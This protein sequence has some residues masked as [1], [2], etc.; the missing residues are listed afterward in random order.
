MTGVRRFSQIP[1]ATRGPQPGDQFVAVSDGTVDTLFSTEQVAAS[2]AP[3]ATFDTLGVVMPD[4][5]TTFVSASGV[6]SAPA[7]GAG[8]T[9][10]SATVTAAQLAAIGTTPVTVIPAP[11]ADLMVVVMSVTYAIV[12]GSVGFS[13]GGSGCGLYYGSPTNGISADA[14]G[15]RN[16][17][18][19]VGENFTSMSVGVNA[20]GA[21]DQSSNYANQAIEYGN[22]SGIDYGGGGSV[23]MQIT[24]LYYI[25]P[26]VPGSF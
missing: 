17:P 26:C 5:I 18:Q 4:N 16:V 7:S 6:I 20:T 13:S 22:P 25:A 19:A 8:V 23:N 3:V 14:Y 21:Q 12:S 2:I 1:R 15:D 11:G 10:L 24:V 9:L